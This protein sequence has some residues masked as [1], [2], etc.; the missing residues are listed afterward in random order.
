[1]KHSLA[2]KEILTI[3]C[4]DINSKIEAILNDYFNR[5]IEHISICDVSIILECGKD[6][7]TYAGKTVPTKREVYHLLQKYI[8]RNVMTNDKFLK[9]SLSDCVNECMKNYNNFTKM[10]KMIR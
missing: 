1:M 6:F 3:L 8:K 10:K 5:I 4:A 2:K 7:D 9:R